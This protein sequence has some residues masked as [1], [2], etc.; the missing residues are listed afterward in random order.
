MTAP[1]LEVSDL[2]ITLGTGARAI[3]IVDVVSFSI[4]PGDRLE[5]MEAPTQEELYILRLYDP[6][7]QFLR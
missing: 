7:K 6:Y 1:L 5:A 3:D 2:T 4:A